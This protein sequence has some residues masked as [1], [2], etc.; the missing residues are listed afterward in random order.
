MTIK[1]V[2]LI[3]SKNGIELRV[4]GE[5]SRLL[6]Q[7]VVCKNWSDASNLLRYIIRD[8]QWAILN[9]ETRDQLEKHALESL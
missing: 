2:S 3:S 9:E 6:H 4:F 8:V 5:K 1:I 7:E